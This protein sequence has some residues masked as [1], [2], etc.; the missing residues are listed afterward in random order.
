MRVECGHGDHEDDSRYTECVIRLFVVFMLF[1]PHGDRPAS[2]EGD[3]VFLTRDGC[4]N[5]PDMVN[6]LDD[7]LAGLKRPKDYAYINIDRLPKTDVRTG[8]PTPTILWKG[9]DCA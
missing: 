3:L 2:L 9:R 8:Y 1:L 4:V 5:T 6:N 7:A